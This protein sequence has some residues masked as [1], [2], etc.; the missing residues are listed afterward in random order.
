MVSL[1][2]ESQ[3]S[4]THLSCYPS[5]AEWIFSSSM[6]CHLTTESFE[7]STS[8]CDTYTSQ[9]NVIPAVSKE[10]NFYAQTPTL[11]EATGVSQQIHQRNRPVSCH[12]SYS[13]NSDVLEIQIHWL[14]WFDLVSLVRFSRTGHRGDVRLPCNVSLLFLSVLRKPKGQNLVSP[15]DVIRMSAFV[16]KVTNFLV[17]VKFTADGH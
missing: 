1:Q 3:L 6:V 9:V 5:W 17:S 15:R 13:D 7:A 16:G 14:P 8:A 10:I 2:K 12:M 4:V 11:T